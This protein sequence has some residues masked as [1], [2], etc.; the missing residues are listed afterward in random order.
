MSQDIENISSKIFYESLEDDDN[1]GIQINEIEKGESSQAAVV[2]LNN[3]FT[4]L[5]YDYQILHGSFHQDSVIVSHS[6]KY[7]WETVYSHCCLC[8]CYWT[9]KTTLC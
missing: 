5:L 8:T 4:T 7:L 1:V 9:N 2:R 3:Y 6:N